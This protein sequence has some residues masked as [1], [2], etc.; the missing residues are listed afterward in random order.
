[1]MMMDSMRD[2]VEPGAKWEFDAGVT[3]VFEDMLERSIPQ[4][5]VMRDLVTQ[6][7]TTIAPQA[8]TTRSSVVVDLGSSRGAALAPIVDRLGAHAQ[9]HAA[10]VSMPMLE[11][12]RARWPAE[13][14]DEHGVS[15]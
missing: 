7:A 1:M 14:I 4:Y 2:E 11:T 10:E 12:L 5:G 15:V 3:Q 6:L 8:P 13:R 9:Y